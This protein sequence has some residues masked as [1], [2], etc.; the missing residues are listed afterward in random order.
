MIQLQKQANFDCFDE[1]VANC[2]C[3]KRVADWKHVDSKRDY[4]EKV[5]NEKIH[6]EV[7]GPD[8]LED[9]TQCLFQG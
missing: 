7:L 2:E 9:E 8:P 6:D 4:F 5:H 1:S 3:Y